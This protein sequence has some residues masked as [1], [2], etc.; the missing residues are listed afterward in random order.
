MKNT[1]QT[2]LATKT[3]LFIFAI[4]IIAALYNKAAHAAEYKQF[5][6]V[7]GKETVAEKAIIAALNGQEAFKCVSVEAKVSKAGTSIGLKNLKKPKSA[8]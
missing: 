1:Y 5:F 8:K 3:T 2:R 4:T 7:N 6:L